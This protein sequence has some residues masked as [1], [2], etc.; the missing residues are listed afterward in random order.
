M[1]VSSCFVRYENAIS[2]PPGLFC[3]EQLPRFFCQL[4]LEKAA[5][6]RTART[7]CLTEAVAIN[8]ALDRRK[9]RK[10]SNVRSTAVAEKGQ[11]NYLT[12]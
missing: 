2:A 11:V 7:S 9:K 12:F 4:K 1:L 5:A 8:K 6:T 10:P 3:F